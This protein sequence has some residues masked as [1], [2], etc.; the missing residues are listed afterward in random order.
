MTLRCPHC[1][2]GLPAGAGVCPACGKPAA[3][4]VQPWGAP[5][6]TPAG[7][8]WP[9]SGSQR[10]WVVPAVVAGIAV[11]ALLLAAFTISGLSPR[12]L[13]GHP[14]EYF[15]FAF[16]QG[17]VFVLLIRFADVYEREPL[18]L[19]ALLAVWGATGAIM[20]GLVGGVTVRTLLPA[21]VETLFGAAISAPLAEETAKGVA[22]LAV[23]LGSRWLAG[24]LGTLEFEGVTDGIVYGAAIGMGFALAE[25]L[26][27][28]L[29]FSRNGSAVGLQV[30]AARVDLF[31]FDMLGHS[32]Y[33]AAFGA[34]L[35]LATVS[36]SR[37]A[38]L[39]FPLLGLAVAMLMHATWNGLDRL[40]LVRRFGFDATVTY[41][42]HFRE[43]ANAPTPQFLQMLAA[44]LQARRATELLY[45]GFLAACA[46][47]FFIWLR[48]Q[49]QVLR[50]E[51]AEEVRLGVV[52]PQD[53]DLLPSPRTRASQSL[54]LLRDGRLEEWGA[55]RRLQNEEVELAFLKWR[56]RRLGGD[57]TQ[58]DRRRQRIARLRAEV[59]APA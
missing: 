55:A 11:T 33:T 12:D 16:L 58:V 21:R 13:V 2:A 57:W 29:T 8:R 9:G 34:G 5:A 18:G 45:L 22:L 30:F 35:G 46:V 24:R 1:G 56:L 44:E 25:D 59:T 19:L 38:R 6:V 7:R 17:A 47:A 37:R 43:L 32:L 4:P 48:Y 14:A 40:V 27:Y 10:G 28:F 36:R 41:L 42:E 52:A 53:W 54:R 26:A 15:V 31:S 23:V 50:Y 3:A 20:L 49:R 51:L 39:G